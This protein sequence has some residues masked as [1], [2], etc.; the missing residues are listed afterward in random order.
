MKKYIA[1]GILLASILLTSCSGSNSSAANE[2]TLQET[3]L[4]ESAAAEETSEEKIALNESTSPVESG[5]ESSELI[6]IPEEDSFYQKVAEVLVEIGVT[7][8]YSSTFSAED[9]SGDLDVTMLMET[10]LC[11]L[12]LDCLYVSMTGNWMII[13][14]S[15]AENG[16]PYY[17]FDGDRFSDIYDYETDTLISESREDMATQDVMQEFNE[18]MESID[19]EFDQSMESIADKYGLDY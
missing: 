17:V 7:N 13:E 11:T 15:N 14:V 2:T 19:A 6:S 16:H 5:E 10:D 12:K 3:V 8:V 4:E 18:Q 1:T 9:Q